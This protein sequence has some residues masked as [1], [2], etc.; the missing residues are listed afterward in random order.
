ML[1][2][3]NVRRRRCRMYSHYFLSTLFLLLHSASAITT[4]TE[5]Q[6]YCD[7]GSCECIED[8]VLCDLKD[9]SAD[10][11]H[12]SGFF[13][14]TEEL[15]S[16]NCETE[17]LTKHGIL[18]FPTAKEGEYLK[19]VYPKKS[20]LTMKNCLQTPTTWRQAKLSYNVLVKIDRHTMGFSKSHHQW[21]VFVTA[22]PSRGFLPVKLTLDLNELEYLEVKLICTGAADVALPVD[23]FHAL[24]S[25]EN[26]ILHVSDKAGGA[27][28]WRNLTATHFH[29]LQKLKHLDLAGNRMRTLAVDLFT[30]L[31]KLRH[32]NLSFNALQSLP[33][34]LLVAQQELITLDLSGNALEAL[35]RNFFKNTKWLQELHLAHN[36]LSVPTNVIENVG[37]LFSLR[38]LDLSHNRFEDLLGSGEYEN[39]TLLTGPQY[40][41]V[42]SDRDMTINLSHNRITRFSFDWVEN[43]YDCNYHYD[44]SH[45]NITH[46]PF[47]AAA[48]FKTPE[49]CQRKWTLAHN[50]LQC[51]CQMSWLAVNTH[52]F[53]A[54]DWQCAAPSPLRARL[55]ITLTRAEL[56]SW[57]PNVCPSECTCNY[58]FTELIVNCSATQLVE[59]PPIP[60]PEQVGLRSTSLYLNNNTI[61]Q[62]PRNTIF[63]YANV[64]RLYV[65]HNRLI[66]I[67]P[68]HLP[69]NLTIL[70]LRGNQLEHLSDDFLLTYLS[71][72]GTLKQLYLSNNPWL[73][74]CAAELLLR[75][76]RIQSARIPD[77]SMLI[78]ANLPNVSLKSVDLA[79]VCAS[80]DMQLS[81]LF[82]ALLALALMVIVLISGIALFYKY[83]LQVKIW[84]YA[85]HIEL[86]SIDEQPGNEMNKKFDAFISYA[87]Q[88]EDYVNRVLLP[89]LEHGVPPFRICIH[90]RNWLVGA[91]IPEQIVESVEQSRRT[92]IV[93]SQQFV[94]SDWGRMEFRMAH[95]CALNEERARI[96]IIKYGELTNVAALDKELQAYLHMN[97]YLEWN[98]PRFWQKLRYAMPHK[99]SEMKR[100]GMLQL[101]S[102]VRFH[103][104]EQLHWLR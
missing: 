3:V 32:L 74:D 80:V 58:N 62:L 90:E 48:T 91:Y 57:T 60:R 40:R 72:N 34:E 29:D 14:T 5:E 36:R 10:I 89:G 54:D 67:T 7:V 38:Q 25:V 4:I 96:I 59:V 93:L 68:S 19:K 39:T 1:L 56:C 11:L 8:F 83:N 23:I 46:V 47:L 53:E 78:C 18:F 64:S 22:G 21:D 76:V 33:A 69:T 94:E 104:G 70:D 45:N 61:Y 2:H 55:P 88:Q 84:L 103:E 41:F 15:F 82:I 17:V 26:L 42:Y 97:T 49:N 37:G 98:D 50:P 95:Q 43:V 75:A 51:D 24:H 13:N 35:P 6:D 92:I 73:C 65:A 102:R 79:Q 20:E 66:T 81:A 44:L 85:H 31:P 100:A 87:H 30:P 71:E 99:S 12:L 77:A 16:N 101:P 9:C 86:C 63:G 27:A 28:T 52:N